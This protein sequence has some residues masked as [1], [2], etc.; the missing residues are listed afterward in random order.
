MEQGYISRRDFPRE[1][2]SFYA[3]GKGH[4]TDTRHQMT[5]TAGNSHGYCIFIRGL[6]LNHETSQHPTGYSIFISGNF[7]GGS[8]SHESQGFIFSIFGW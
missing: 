5:F 4:K 7:F 1:L 2:S 8:D 6:Q 3:Q